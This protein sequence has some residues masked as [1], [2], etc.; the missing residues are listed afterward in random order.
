MQETKGIL[1]ELHKIEDLIKSK[2]I[3]IIELKEDLRQANKK[4][5]MFKQALE[6][7]K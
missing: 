1:Q 2:D 4:L 3:K 7:V 5:G 6:G